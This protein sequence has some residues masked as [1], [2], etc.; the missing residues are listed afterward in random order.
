MF[1][2][3]VY[4]HGVESRSKRIPRSLLRG[5][6]AIRINYYY[7]EDQSALQLVAECFNNNSSIPESLS[8]SRYVDGHVTV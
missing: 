1:Q 7:L 5:Q 3:N 8:L 4:C 2:T 6:R